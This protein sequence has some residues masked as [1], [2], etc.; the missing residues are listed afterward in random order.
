MHFLSAMD[1]CRFSP[2]IYLVVVLEKI[3]AFGLEVL[4]NT[5]I[6]IIDE[7]KQ[8]GRKQVFMKEGVLGDVRTV[9]SK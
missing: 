6:E 2:K 5:S 7:R 4:A 3:V 1:F 9:L 8:Q